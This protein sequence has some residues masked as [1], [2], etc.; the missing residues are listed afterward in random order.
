MKKNNK[1]LVLALL[2]VLAFNAC[3]KNEDNAG[4]EAPQ[5]TVAP[6][7]TVTQAPTEAP[8]DENVDNGEIENAEPAALQSNAEL[9][10]FHAKA[11]EIVGENYRPSMPY[12]TVMLEEVFG[13]K[14]EWYDAAIAE[15]PMMSAH[16]DKLVA[17]HATEGNL[18]NV[19][20]ALKAYRETIVNDTM[21]YPMNVNRIQASIVETVGDY[22]L[23]VMVGNVDETQFEL[24]DE[25]I[26]A[27]AE[28][29][30]LVVD[31]AKEILVK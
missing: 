27:L 8:V 4:Q 12:D 28:Q 24:D 11:K 15:G 14:P 20:N 18:E 16:V 23:F 2:I 21:N 6:T 30:Q 19:Q 3:G 5:T 10:A 13:V 29:N 1:I 7:E 17:I 26:A 22:V 31:A 25:M 9:D